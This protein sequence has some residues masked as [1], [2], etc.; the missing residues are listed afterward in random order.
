MRLIYAVF[1]LLLASMTSANCQ[2]TAEDWYNKGDLLDDDENWEEALQAYINAHEINPQNVTYLI[3]IGS[4][5]DSMERYDD[6]VQ[7][8]DEILK[9]YPNYYPA[10]DEKAGTLYEAKNYD[11]ALAATDKAI[12]INPD[13]MKAWMYRPMILGD[14]GR[15]T[16]ADSADATWQRLY[17]RVDYTSPL[18]EY[19]ISRIKEWYKMGILTNQIAADIDHH[20]IDVMTEVE[21]M[22]A[23][24]ELARRN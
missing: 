4:T 22:I 17:D 2:Q 13:D 5:L 20:D 1:I 11:E 12:A 6:A 24:G 15:I 10:L 23:R 14:M 18:S 3:A 16:E 8:Y 21:S 9:M 19:D 7:T